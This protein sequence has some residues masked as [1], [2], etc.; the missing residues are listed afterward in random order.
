MSAD[1][2][3]QRSPNAPGAPL[4][5]AIEIAK[6]LYLAIRGA[7]VK[8]DVAVKSLG[9]SGLHGAALTVLG[10]LTQYDLINRAKGLVSITPLALRIIHPTS[11]SQKAEAI[12]EAAVAPRVFQEL[13]QE[14]HECAP[15]VLENHLIH[16]GFI[17]DKAKKVASVYAANKTFAKLDNGVTIERNEKPLAGVQS[18]PSDISGSKPGPLSHVSTPVLPLSDGVVRYRR[19]A[20][21]TEIKEGCSPVLAQYSIPLGANEAILTFTGT[22]LTVDDF[23]ALQ[24]YV[25]LFKRQFARKTKSSSLLQIET[26]PDLTPEKRTI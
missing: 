20:I 2:T 19:A 6:R 18:T 9:Y 24:E 12:R 7:S 17:P 4:E 3:K 13:Q 16:Q 21:D 15:N 23:D 14:F 26:A 10:V 8:P 5:E 25:D 1:I 11:D 22:E